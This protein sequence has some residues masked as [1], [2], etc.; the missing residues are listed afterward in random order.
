[1]SLLD[2][3]RSTGI[4]VE[5]D[6]DAGVL[7]HYPMGAFGASPDMPH[8]IAKLYLTDQVSSAMDAED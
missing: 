6:E 4:S 3:L 2:N 5:I 8:E 1:M 7:F